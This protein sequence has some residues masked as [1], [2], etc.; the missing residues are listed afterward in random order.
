V[1]N[2]AL[3]SGELAHEP[4][5]ELFSQV[6]VPVAEEL[7]R[8]TFLGAVTADGRR[9]VSPIDWRTTGSGLIRAIGQPPPL[10]QALVA[11]DTVAPF[12][13]GLC[14]LSNCC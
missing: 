10:G 6:A 2:G 5:A 9:R 1:P 3:I 7:T 12:Q 4:L 14:L 11:A 8:G 13:L